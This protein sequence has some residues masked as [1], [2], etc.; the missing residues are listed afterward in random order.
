[1]VKYKR[2]IY[3]IDVLASSIC[4]MRCS[5]CYLHKNSAYKEFDLCLKK[6]WQDGTYVKNLKKVFNK[7][8]ANMNEVTEIGFWGGEPTLGLIDIIPNIKKILEYFPNIEKFFMSTNWTT[9]I[10]PIIDLIQE[11]DLYATHPIQIGIQHSIDGP[12]GPITEA[13]HP[14][15][16]AVYWKN[17][18]TF[19]NKLENLD[20]I[21]VNYIRGTINSNIAKDV[22]YDNIKN[23]EDLVNYMNYM[24]NISDEL[25]KLVVP[26]NNKYKEQGKN[27][28][29]DYI[30]GAFPGIAL[31]FNY[32]VEDGIE[33]LR[34][35]KIWEA[36]ATTDLKDR[37]LPKVFI[38]NPAQ[39]T[40]A[41][42]LLQMQNQC[43]HFD[44]AI[45]VQHDGTIVHCNGAYINNFL[46]YIEEL[47]KEQNQDELNFCAVTRRNIYNPLKMT[48]EE[49]DRMQTIIIHGYRNNNSTYNCL[50]LG[51]CKELALSHQISE[52]FAY[53]I[54]YL[55]RYLKY[56]G[57]YNT[58]NRENER[59]C[60]ITFLGSPSQY[61]YYLNGLLQSVKEEFDLKDKFYLKEG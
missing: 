47:K 4:N 39:F 10:T 44:N 36:I 32:T 25:K 33:A 3:N 41:I 28:C 42:S 29:I 5:F 61:R 26:I 55:Q 38:R 45:T 11:I 27:F 15:K 19:L 49:I 14:G 35:N 12:E 2:H 9:D 58:C 53:D 31:P 23:Y 60:G 18:K 30:S 7:L 21:H 20:L 17:W 16:Y 1:M 40:R 59:A 56:L 22:F 24:L 34:Y 50:R 43:S 37:N 57:T 6:A 8:N 13:G 48:D 51:M 46:P 52:K 54:E